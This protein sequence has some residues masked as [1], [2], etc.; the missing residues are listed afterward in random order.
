MINMDEYYPTLKEFRRLAKLGNLIPV[1]CVLPADL[2]TPL[3]AYL[4][5][6]DDEYSYLLESV[7]GGEQVARYSFLGGKPELVVSFSADKVTRREQGRTRIDKF[8]GDPLDYLK[9]I[10]A[11]YSPVRV[12][13]L[14]PFHG[15]LVGY[16]GYEMAGNWEKISQSNPDQL[17]FPAGLFMLTD[18]MVIFDHVKH[19]LMVVAN[20]YISKGVDK[21]Y[22][23]AVRKIKRL[24]ARLQRPLS[25]SRTGVARGSSG[26]VR[27]HMKRRDYEQM[28]RQAKR[29]IRAGDIIQVVLSQRLEMTPAPPPL[30][31]YRMLRRVNPSPYM[32]FLRLGGRCLVGASPELLVSLHGDRLVIKPIA[33][34]RPRGVNEAADLRLER[35]LLRDPK[36]KA[37]HVML[38]DLG[39]NDLGRVARTGSVRVEN[40]MHIERFSHVMHIVSDVVGRLRRGCDGFDALR[41]AFP[42]GTV[43]GAPKIRAME[44]IDELESLGR[45]PYGGAVGNFSFSGDMDWCLT[46]RTIM[47]KGRRAYLQAG[48]G[49]VADSVPSREYQETLNKA[50]AFIKALQLAGR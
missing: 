28:V 2:E 38:V 27:Y 17:G 16:L 43:S 6:A 36:E 9:G 50:Q 22:A 19:Q 23:D 13:G 12:A 41:S 37:E 47:M 1:Y 7:E 10:M 15:G 3:S 4:K 11:K 45:G 40:F 34:T 42:H 24:S 35:E 5:S 33:G 30:E 25:Y 18:S 48:A 46:I 49:I 32:F 44:I 8:T 14:P 31:V 20:A 29:Y 26:K 21:A 39:R